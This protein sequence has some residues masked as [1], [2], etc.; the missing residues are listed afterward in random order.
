MRRRRNSCKIAVDGCCFNPS[1]PD[2][3]A[4]LIVSHRLAHRRIAIRVL[5]WTLAVLPLFAVAC[6]ES[7]SGFGAGLRARS[8]ADQ[9]FGALAERHVDILRNS[10]Y[11]YAKLQLSRGALSPSRVFDDTAAWTGASGPVRILET[12]GAYADDKYV[13]TAH[14]GVPVP[15]KPADGRHVTTLSRLTDNQYRWDTSVDFALGSA[16][17]ND[18]A[19]VISRL[20]TAGEGLSERDARADLLA[21]A[22]RTSVAL[23]GVFTLDSLHPVQLGDGTTAVTLG[24]SVRSEQLKQRF[25]A[26]GEYVHRYVDPARFR[27]LVS[28]R[29]G[30][31]YIDAQYKDRY[32]TIRVRSEGGR[33]VPLAGPP[34]PIPDTLVVLADFAVKVKMFTVGFH[35]LSAEFVNSAHGDK[36]RDWTVIARKEPHWNLPFITAR[37][38]RAP[39]RYPFAGEGALFR[40]GLRAG[41]GELP[42]VLVRQTRLAVQESA[43]LKFINSLT[44][45][46]IDDFGARVEKEEN[47]WL[48]ELFIGLRDD[49]RTVLA[50]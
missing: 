33:L 14:R 13:M 21:S 31:P 27:F 35:D 45:T 10:K 4:L 17:P 18:V 6:R 2:A 34:K 44:N 40:M 48:H 19:L 16:R 28:D 11:D 5:A 29:A 23:G 49:A 36:E 37:L 43:I 12:F 47:Q 32:L 3:G 25:P 26:F 42:T 38:I 20:L 46:A 8:S 9:F 41:E 1:L 50:P 15:S 22:P 30:V 7:L 39:L 24:I